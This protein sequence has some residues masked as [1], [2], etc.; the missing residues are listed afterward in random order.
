VC[1]WLWRRRAWSLHED[2]P[3]RVA[4]VG[5]MVMFIDRCSFVRMGNLLEMMGDSRKYE[6]CAKKCWVLLHVKLTNPAGI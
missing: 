5:F 4:D 6:D 1:L 3:T 2:V